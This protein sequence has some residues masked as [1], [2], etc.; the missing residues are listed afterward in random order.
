MTAYGY[1]SLP[2]DINAKPLSN[3][4]F[5]Q[6]M[7][8]LK[9]VMESDEVQA[10]EIKIAYVY[11]R[12]DHFATDPFGGKRNTSYAS[13]NDD[14]IVQLTMRIPNPKGYAALTRLVNLETAIAQEALE[15][16]RHEL[17]MDIAAEDA[18]AARAKANADAKRAKLAE[19]NAK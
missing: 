6:G 5:T 10:Q 18:E 7:A 4:L 8:A 16:E 3:E 12:N 1:Y 17:E 15:A 11:D 13:D 2:D 9:E 14:V 19:L